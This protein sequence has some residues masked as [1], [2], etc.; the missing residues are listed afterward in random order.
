M[1]AIVFV[2]LI[3]QNPAPIA[4]AAAALTPSQ[5]IV[6]IDTTKIKG[7][8][9]RLAW[10]PDRSELYV[11]TVERDRQ[12]A[13]KSAKHFLVSVEGR[14]MKSVDAEPAWAA[15]YW[16]WKSGQASPGTGV[17]KIAVSSRQENVRATS[18]PVGGAL[19]KGGL[20]DASVGTTV[21]D[22]AAVVDQTQKKNIYTLKV[23]NQTI[24]EWVN[25]PVMP[26]VNFGWAPAPMNALVFTKREGGPLLIIDANGQKQ[27]LTG[28][29]AALL[30][31]FSN[32][33]SRVAWMERID[34]KKFE[35]R[36]ADFTAK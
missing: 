14:S 36:I 31:A 16:T 28:A 11:Q 5:P 24:G 18:A 17:M 33:G 23:V 8:P 26:G 20:P 25:E 9:A 19:A 21:E 22:A 3:A 30:P 27:E 10:S 12:G 6:E 2:A 29:K 13:V 7:D 34:R 15:R 35:I 4:A 1:F 32:D